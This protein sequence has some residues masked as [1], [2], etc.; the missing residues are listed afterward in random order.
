MPKPSRTLT[1]IADLAAHDLLGRRDPHAL[2]AVAARYAVAIPPA[3]AE[4]IDPAD[5]EDPIARQ[6]VPDARELVTAPE[7]RAD[8]IGDAAHS[9]VKGIVHR[10]PD[11]VLLKL[12]HLCPVYCRFCFRREMI[13]PANG[14]ALTAAELSRALAYIGAHPDVFEVIITGG[15]PLVVSPRRIAGLTRA[16]EAFDH[17]KVIR[18]HSRVPVVTP[19]RVTDE[20]VAA[21]ASRTGRTVVIGVHANHARELTEAARAALRRLTSGGLMLVGQSV[22]LEGVNDDPETLAALMRALLAAGV[23]PYYLHHADLAPGTSHFRTSIAEGQALVRTLRGRLSGLAQPT[24][25]VDTPGGYGKVPIGP[26]FVD[27]EAEVT[28][29]TDFRGRV[30]AYPQRPGGPDDQRNGET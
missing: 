2:A 9:P 16:L 7:E 19:E 27:R 15:D 4:L 13:G 25:V 29:I 10:Y 26:S 22:L 18:W 21:L 28:R 8:P 1:T 14:A 17:V 5:P 20:L 30:H 11:R 23:K 3:M 12:T 6:F 24:Y